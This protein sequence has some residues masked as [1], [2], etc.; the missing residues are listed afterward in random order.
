MTANDHEIAALNV[1]IEHV[2]KAIRDLKFGK[3]G[4]RWGL[5][6]D[7]GVDTPLSPLASASLGDRMIALKKLPQLV[8]TLKA[9]HSLRVSHLGQ[10]A[11]AARDFELDALEL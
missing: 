10:L 7:Y 11:E 8:K 4:G 9:V 6:L 3:E 5:Y 1:A 2:E